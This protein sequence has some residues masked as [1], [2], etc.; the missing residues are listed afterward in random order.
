M[1]VGLVGGPDR[2]LDR[3]G[4]VEA[5][6]GQRRLALEAEADPALP[7]RPEGVDARGPP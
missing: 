4:A 1:P 2:V 7:G 5:V 6:D 3:A